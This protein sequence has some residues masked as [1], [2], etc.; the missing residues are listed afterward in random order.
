MTVIDFIISLIAVLSLLGIVQGMIN[1]QNARLIKELDV[2][3][4]RLQ[5]IIGVGK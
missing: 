1:Y 5:K 4:A 3:V 2:A